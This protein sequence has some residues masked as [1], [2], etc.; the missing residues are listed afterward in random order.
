MLYQIKS[1]KKLISSLFNEEKLSLL[2]FHQVKLK[3]EL[4]LHRYFA[5]KLKICFI[6]TCRKQYYFL[7]YLVK[8]N[9]NTGDPANSRLVGGKTCP[10]IANP[11]T[12]R[13]MGEMGTL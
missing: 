10:R 5:G 1:K 2:I 8:K 3:K 12:S 11:P 6:K 7:T 13:T 9:P 4:I